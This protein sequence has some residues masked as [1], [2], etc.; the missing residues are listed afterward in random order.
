MTSRAIHCFLTVLTCSVCLTAV[1]H[2]EDLGA[3]AKII[4]FRPETKVQEKLQARPADAAGNRYKTLH[5]ERARGNLFLH[6]T[7]LAITKMPASEGRPMAMAALMRY[8]RGHLDEFV[9]PAKFKTTFETPE[10]QKQWAADASEGSVVRF[11]TSGSASEYA[12]MLSES[13][14]EHLTLTTVASSKSAT[15]RLVSGNVWISIATASPLEGCILRVRSAFRPT[16]AATHDDEWKVAEDFSAL[17]VDFT[18]RVRSFVQSHSGDSLPELLPPTLANVPWTS[19]AKSF[20]QPTQA[21]AGVEGMWRSVDRE[22]RFR[23]E[24]LGDSSCDFIE[25]N[26][27]GVELRMNLPVIMA[28][29]PKDGF[30]I[31]RPNDRDEVMEFYDFKPGARMRIMELKPEPS[32]LVLKRNSKGRLLGNWYGFSITS[33]ASGQVSALKQ[34]S[35]MSAKLFEF[36]QAAE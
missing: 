35:T 15:E 19:V 5:I 1:S 26:S 8:M 24:F 22:Q 14:T 2:A 3:W 25:R 36:V 4:S 20:H 33:D 10:E 28:A 16:L 6:S 9:D 29:D 11:T 13:T 12:F 34:P 27:K 23:I 7:G 18:D 30:T 32:K 17:W 21:W 31:E